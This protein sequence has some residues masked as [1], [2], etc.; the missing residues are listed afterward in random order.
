V[1]LNHHARNTVF[2]C[3]DFEYGFRSADQAENESLKRVFVGS[4]HGMVFQVNYANE[5]LE[6]TYKTNDAAI[7]SIAVNDAFCVT[8]SEDT[9][10]RI[11]PLDFQE[12]FMEAQHEGT[13][14][15]VDISPD[16]LKVV[17]GT[18]YGSIGILDK[19][20][21]NYKTLL[22]SHTAEIL[23]ADFH[24]QK[25]N[26]ITV[27]RDRTIRLWDIETNDQVSEF[28]AT[29][30]Q[31]LCVSAH[32][33]L[34]IFAVGF[35]SGKM[36]IFDIDTTEVVDQ[37]SQFNKPIKSLSYD[38]TGRILIACCQDGS[39][40]VHNATRQHLP[41]K[42]MHLELVPEFVHIAFSEQVMGD[43]D[44]DSQK[45]A[46]MGDY[47][48]NILIYDTDSFLVLHH[49]QVNHVVKSFKFAN[50]NR[51]IVVVTKDCKVRFYSL[52]KYE[53][54]FLREVANCHRG[55]ITG[56]TISANSGY[57]LTGGED[58]MIKLWDYEAQKTVP[59]YFQ[60]F[61][62][63]TYPVNQIMFN[64]KDNS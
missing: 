18:T 8:G 2:T 48:N 11:W 49:I 64:P 40:S 9:Y 21:Q 34:P 30:D 29:T 19:S 62:G 59:Y 60:S 55:S 43:L 15:T 36:N 28:S 25:N 6:A 42:M 27:S 57:M 51:D 39:T 41:I 52:L 53:G 31:P 63:H 38:A 4:K 14:S 47:G 58:N 22:R 37:F 44:G 56:S 61:I 32:P 23:A 46:V 50:N 17:C 16:G 26:I 54:I 20:N 1:V 33:T 12:F 24:R 10:L 45:F 5:T 13:V 7:Y 3:L 35:E